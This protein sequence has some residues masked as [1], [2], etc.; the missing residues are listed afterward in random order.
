MQLS[1]TLLELVI[2]AGGGAG[3]RTAR[4]RGRNPKVRAGTAM[5]RI[6]MGD[7]MPQWDVGSYLQFAEERTQPAVDLA[8]RIEVAHPR[9]II[10]LGCGPGNST[11]VL[12]RRWPGARVIGL[13]NSPEMIAAASK[14]NPEETWVLADAATWTAKIPCDIVFSSAALQWL[15]DHGRLFPHLMGQVAPGGVLAV[16]LPAHHGTTAHHAILQVADDPRWSH[17]M[18]TARNAM[19]RESPHF[20]YDVLQPLASRLFIWTTEYYHVLDGPRAIL[21]WFRGTGLRPFLAALEDDE[22]RRHFEDELVEG[23]S[24]IYP[25]QRNGLVLF[26]FRRLFMLAYAS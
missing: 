12:R 24:G 5:M 4:D 25:R 1:C 2:S 10:D 7:P 18:G 6:Y 23:F 8:A 19:T 16:Q 11:A 14:S 3:F 21:E 26:P 17:L 9:H 22:Q 20:Y 13:D 15:P